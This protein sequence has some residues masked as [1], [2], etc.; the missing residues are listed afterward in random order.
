MEAI[1]A[2]GHM[3]GSAPT[4]SV[5]R[6]ALRLEPGDYTLRVATAGMFPVCPETEVSVAAGPVVTV[7]IGCDTGIR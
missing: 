2:A 6:Y 5:G 3:A 4:D 7:D 1:D